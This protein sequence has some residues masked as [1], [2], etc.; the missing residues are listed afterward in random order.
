[1]ILEIVFCVKNIWVN[2]MDKTKRLI[3]T[4]LTSGIAT[5]LSFLISFLLTPYITNQLGAE[6][7]GFVTLSKNFAS[8]ATIIATA[9]NSYAARY[10]AVE[11]HRGN[12]KNANI[13]VSSVFAGD[14][15][16][17]GSIFAVAIIFIMSLEKFLNISANLIGSVKILFFFVFTEFVITTISTPFA[18]AAY[19]KNR[20]DIIG[21][22]R[23]LSYIVEVIVYIILFKQNEIRIWYVGLALIA[24]SVIVFIGNI[25]VFKNYTPELKIS[26]DNISIQAIKRLVVSGIW[27]AI[28]SLGNTLNSGLDLIITN[29]MLSGLAMGQLAITKTI[30]GIFGSFNQLLAQPF[31]PLFLKSYSENNMTQLLKELKVSMKVTGL[32]S[33]LAFAIFCSLGKLFYQLW[34]PE[35]NIE[36]I[37]VLTIL[38]MVSLVIEGPVYPLYYIYTLTVKNKIPCII[39]VIGGGLNL[40]G[41]YIL[42]KFTQMG[43]YSVVLTTTVIMSFI[44]LVTNPIYMT[45]CLK[46]KW[47]TF[48][49]TLLRSCLSC[50]IM[51]GVFGKITKKMAMTGWSGLVMMAIL[52]SVL[53]IVI[54]IIVVFS[55]EERA[56]VANY[57]IKRARIRY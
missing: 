32:F 23:T 19:I 37:Y 55:H 14:M 21:I 51:T 6:A 18:S 24:A 45:K 15:I 46:V 33:C 2:K 29:L 49:P 10:I 7:Y 8:Y 57:I 43:I 12:M 35:Q 16:I 41:M 1:M 3:F 31:Q 42:I 13:Y 20:L 38:T 53:G 4:I 11:F 27:N 17:A 22:F 30:S 48:Y 47:Y 44:N 25:F 34:I 5:M 54:H 28:N 39:T 50:I 52:C 40:I 56:M 26:K 36:L 9:V